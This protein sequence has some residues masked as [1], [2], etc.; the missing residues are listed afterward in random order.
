MSSN[1][2]QNDT[3]NDISR[4]EK[5]ERITLETCREPIA[6]LVGASARK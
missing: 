4:A 2:S 6:C 1:K 5:S 3:E